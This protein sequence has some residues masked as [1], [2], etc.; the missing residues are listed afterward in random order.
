M[1]ERTREGV[2][3]RY[4]RRYNFARQSRYRHYVHSS[5]LALLYNHRTKGRKKTIVMTEYFSQNDGVKRRV[6][7][8]QLRDNSQAREK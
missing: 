7:P 3:P 8:R 1:E 6:T 5:H 4:E 2:R